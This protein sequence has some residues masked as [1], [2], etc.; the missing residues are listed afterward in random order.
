MDASLSAAKAFPVHTHGSVLQGL[1]EV[2]DGLLE[3]ER[4]IDEGGSLLEGADA[5]GHRR[6]EVLVDVDRDLGDGVEDLPIGCG[7]DRR[8]RLGIGSI[9]DYQAP[10]RVAVVTDPTI[11]S[12]GAG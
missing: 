7:E 11:H 12:G 8:V 3:G 4:F 6:R 9:G 2:A 1:G 5:V 10:R